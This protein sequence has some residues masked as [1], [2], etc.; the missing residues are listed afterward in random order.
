MLAPAATEA[1]YYARLQPDLYKIFMTSL[2]FLYANPDFECNRATHGGLP[3][4]E[5]E[6]LMHLFDSLVVGDAVCLT[7]SA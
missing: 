7:T 1:A 5:G 3:G 6:S 2:C 4:G